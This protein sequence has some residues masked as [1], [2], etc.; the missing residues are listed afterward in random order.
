MRILIIEDEIIIGRDIQQLLD[1]NFD[2][3]TRIALTIEEAK[4]EAMGF[5]PHL[6]LSD[7][8]LND[9][10]DGIELMRYLQER[11]H[12]EVIFITSYPSK[13]VIERA[14]LT[15]PAHYIVKPFDEKQIIASVE[16][17]RYRLLTNALAGTLRVN[18]KELLGKVEFDILRLISQD[19]STKDIAEQLFISPATVKNHRHNISRKLNLAFDNHALIKWVMNNKALI[20]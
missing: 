15:Q 9:V 11:L 4:T 3:E 13:N 10:T 14:A 19:K 20:V 18:V 7:I 1:D 12:F 8:N 16:I 5:M 17:T 2:C 6:I